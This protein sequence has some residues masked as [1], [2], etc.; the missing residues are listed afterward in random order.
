MSFLSV[1]F[2]WNENKW[3]NASGE[4]I[5]LACK[6]VPL[7][8]KILLF[9]G[10]FINCICVYSI[11]CIYIYISI[12]FWLCANLKVISCRTVLFHKYWECLTD[13]GT[14]WTG[15]LFIHTAGSRCV[16]W[17]DSRKCCDS[18]VY[19]ILCTV[20]LQFNG[21]IW[22]WCYIHIV[23]EDEINRRGVFFLVMFLCKLQSPLELQYPVLFNK[24]CKYVFMMPQKWKKTQEIW[25]L[26]Y[27]YMTLMYIFLFDN[28]PINKC[29][30][31]G[32]PI[33]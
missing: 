21:K 30:Q 9:N 12:L 1:P 18:Q 24:K 15:W 19:W 13:N 32:V 8:N 17:L 20:E 25:Y 14:C 33:T 26:F 6:Y 16:G 29:I 5:Y 3:N 23:H 4:N 11:H 22:D 31:F 2:L 28:G 27:K 10:S 7:T